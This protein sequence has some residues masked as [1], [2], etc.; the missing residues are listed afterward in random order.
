MTRRADGTVSIEGIGG[1]DARLEVVP[2]GGS[3]FRVIHEDTSHRVTAVR[4]GNERW[5]FV[6]GRTY[7]IQV[8]GGTRSGGRRRPIHESLA[9]PMPATVTHVRVAPGA[10]VER[11]DVLLILE[12][13]KMELPVR[14]PDAGIVTAIHCAEG[15]LVQPDVALIELDEPSDAG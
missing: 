8:V 7:R 13:M 14:A 12:A 9:A 15:D 10:A 3:N 11:G 2:T 5:V 1:M 6:N 4:D